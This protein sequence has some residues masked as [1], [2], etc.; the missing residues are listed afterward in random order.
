[1]AQSLLI[2]LG[3]TGSRVVNNVTKLLKQ[4]GQTFNN[5]EICCAVLDTN[6][7]DAGE[8]RNSGTEVPVFETSKP[9]RI[10]DYLEQY[11][12]LHIEEW[13]PQSPAFLNQSMIDGASECRV[14]SRV[15][16]M[17]C[18]E[19]GVTDQLEL[20]INQVLRNN[21][22]SKIRI[23]IVSSLSGGTG[24]GMFIQVALWLRKFL[25]Q[26]QITIRGIF[27][28]PDVFVSTIEDIRTNA[29][30]KTR[31]YC[32][33]YAAI[34]E[35]N[36][37]TKI[38][39][40]NSVDL[41]EKISLGDLFDSIID[42]DSGSPVY[43]FAFFVD[44][45]DENGVRLE[46][47][48]E[49]E[50]MVAQLVYMQLYAPM[51]DDMYSEEDNTF[52]AFARNEEPLYGSCGTA[53]IEYPVKSVKTYCAIRAA[54][55]VINTGWRKIDDEIEA[56]QEEI[57]QKEKDGYIVSET[58]DP[59]D[60]YI[61][62]FDQKTSKKPEEV[63]KDR[64]FTGIAKDVKNENPIKGKD[65]KIT[66]NYTD[67]VADFIV[68]LNKEKIDTASIRYSKTDKLKIDAIAFVQDDH[69]VEDLKQRVLSD[70]SDVEDA[71]KAFEKKAEEYAN[72]IVDTVFPYNMGDV[73]PQNA[74][75]IYGLVTKTNR[76]GLPEFI[77]PV[78]A[79]YL[80]YKLVAELEKKQRTIILK[81]SRSDALSGG[82]TDTNPFDNK[83]T[84]D[85]ETT[86]I[87][88]L[89]SKKWS[90]REDKFT[91][92]FERIY[93][94]YFNTKIGLCHKYETE[95]L[96]NTTYNKLIARINLLIAEMEAFF[97]RLKDVRN[98]LTEDMAANLAETAQVSEK[99]VY[100]Y[101]KKEHKEE[102]YRSIDMQIG[103]RVDEVNKGVF[104][105]VYGK[106]CA[107][108]RP[109]V[110]ENQPY[111]KTSIATSFLMNLMKAFRNRI[112]N[113]KNNKELIELDV[114]TA[115]CKESDAK[116]RTEAEK[117]K[118][119]GEVEQ[120]SF[121]DYDV[122]EDEV[123]ENNSVA[124]RHQAAFIEYKNRVH[125]LAAPFLIKAR[126]ISDN[127]FG[128]VTTRVKT[129]WG[130]HPALNEA[131]PNLGT[132]LKVNADIQADNA[133]P[134]NELYCY[135][136]V[137]GLAAQFIPK[138][139]EINGGDYYTCYR[140]VV[141]RMTKEA[142]GARGTRAY[143]DTPHLDYRW[144]NLLPYTTKIMNE[145]DELSF[146]HGFWLAVAYGKLRLNKNGN[147]CL[148]RKVD[149][150]FGTTIDE[151]IELSLR[152][153]PIGKVDIGKLLVALRMDSMF[154]N[155]EI[156]EL[157]GKFSKELE[158]MDTYAGTDVLKGLT[159]KNADINP[160][161]IVCRY[162]DGLNKNSHVS[163]MMIGSLEKIASEL[164]SRYN[165]HR[166]EQQETEAKFRICK[167]I[168]ESSS[169]KKGNTIFSHWIDEFKK[170][171]D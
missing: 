35:L 62:L 33:A 32:N 31:H 124:M 149:G 50:H 34:R 43:D 36:A 81:N 119:N 25:S 148:I 86:P 75:S 152:N 72:A 5:G 46:N 67:K 162:N 128:I 4:N 22:G 131:Y 52:L 80:L 83:K 121:D 93:A 154:R 60:M 130:F 92:E 107:E 45:R 113:N 57:E 58:F 146:Y 122:A 137:Y 96:M 88:Y 134:K 138:F 155:I 73:N 106:V 15:A 13:C 64:F 139:N 167:R 39:Q 132:D 59:R 135:R 23:M 63:G 95:L 78:A 91:D 2:G 170:L 20:M 142:A 44:D 94:E 66:V 161:D 165:A 158:V 56:Q 24:S 114:Y 71:I 14:K 145:K 29:E 16:F 144:H 150:G 168:F 12:H 21:T 116:V 102:I 38:K 171:K 79:R 82:N 136:A 98:K 30:T 105:T 65:G 129:F 17:D 126:E 118:Q 169:R 42:E 120:I 8:I 28:L 18:L 26:S 140:A 53:K 157:E 1:M 3:G 74:C 166:T 153:R 11:H 61:T 141:D 77:H 76:K 112:N 49:Y 84:K 51:K 68:R 110:P 156:P 143:V 123:K 151:E 104:D 48:A 127:E 103:T 7:N 27:L 37:I 97:N 54:R 10:R 101:G 41:P 115:I 163:A 47:I 19:T 109:N 133:Y 87:E 6:I 70:E 69:T 55:E 160:V 117:R 9:Q 125:R 164:A 159:Q 111:G 90:Q 89:E 100:V 40:N 108:K 99:T 85:V 147:F